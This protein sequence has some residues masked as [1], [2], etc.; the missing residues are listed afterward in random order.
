M[1]DVV[2]TTLRS[3]AARWASLSVA[4]SLLAACSS[5]A[6]RTAASPPPAAAP[7]RTAAAA[8]AVAPAE[9]R[10]LELREEAPG[11]ALVLTGSRPLVWTSYRDSSGRLVL[12]LPNSTAASEVVSL[13]PSSGLVASVEVATETGAD[14]PLTRFV[15]ATR[16]DA[17]HSLAA[18][19]DRLLV[20]LVP[21]G[22]SAEVTAA[23]VAYE[24]LPDAQPAAPAEVAVVPA[25]PA[26]ESPAAVPAGE[27]VARVDLGTPE[28][29]AAGLPPSGAPADRLDAVTVQSDR[30]GAEVLIEGN[31]QFTYST[32]L[33]DGPS[34][35]VIDLSGVTNATASSVIPVDSPA[36]ERVRVAQFKAQPEAVARVVVDLTDG[37]VPMVAV[38][39]SGLRVRIA[40]QGQAVAANTTLARDLEAAGPVATAEAQPTEQAPLLPPPAAE[41][42]VPAEQV[43]EQAPPPALPAPVEQPAAEAPAV[44]APTA[45]A[46]AEVPAP[47]AMPA[48][49]PMPPATRP[50]R[51]EA[52]EAAEAAPASEEEA[53]Q[54]T[55]QSFQER[56]ARGSSVKEYVGEPISMQLK[57]ADIR[58][59]LRTFAQISGL[60]IV[61]QPG[62]TGSVTVELTD[63]PWDQAL[64]QI[65]KINNLGMELEGNILRIATNDRLRQEAAE[66]QA[67]KDAQAL[68]VPLETIMKRV[69][70][71][72][73]QEL[74]PVVRRVMSQ[75]GDIIVDE[76]TNTLI[77]KE[78]PNYL[79]TVIA[80]IETLDTPE[81]QV[82]IE[83][84]IVE[85]TKRFGRS[86][87]IQWGFEGVADAAHGNTTGLVFPNTVEGEGGVNLLTGG[88][89]GALSLA[90]G[91][92]LDTFTLEAQLQA[93]EN[94]GLVNILS[95]PK[96]SVLNNNTAEMQSGL[97]IPIQT[98]ANN[99]V[100]VQFVNA[101]LRLNV[102][103]QVTAEG[104]I[105]LQVEVQKRNPELAFAVAGA[106]NAPINTRE[107]RTRVI[108]RDGGTTVIGGIYEVSNDFGEDRVPG[109]AN[110]PVLKHLF[111]NRRS[112]QENKELLIFITPRVIRL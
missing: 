71:A 48:P 42:S 47:A 30:S 87:G 94:E 64:E 73:A 84:R 77:I 13:A 92:I 28:A 67:L 96:V 59:V 50:A 72:R 81:P 14:R 8:P 25:P 29:P 74:M 61:V 40:D 106:T 56:V 95:A 80:V 23:T 103:P 68:S 90:L 6:P 45:P 107:A 70:Y 83:A 33:L 105:L 62:V 52:V 31:G 78:L 97:Q 89:N 18:D 88:R 2:N 26:A 44:I 82:M 57:D 65:L 36:V 69:S 9:V 91:N 39:P 108:V 101:T 85:T 99:T 75:R 100:T 12:E 98:V 32:F 51:V 86:L 4:L 34:R 16:G 37:A 79:K 60:N 49:T 35:F 76:R 46:V 93:A 43:A 110:V 53:R 111:K 19:G 66:A 38:T 1:G 41:P 55:L 15:V 24:P 20:R 10:Q 11:L 58:D 54:A 3:R 104:T 22:G 63:V 21:V 109:L 112:N 7:E 5:S 27:A 17:E 102:T